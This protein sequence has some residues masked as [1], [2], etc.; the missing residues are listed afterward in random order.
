MSNK[1]K[2][3]KFLLEKPGYLKRSALNLQR[4]FFKDIKLQEV[5]DTLLQT[6]KEHTY[7]QYPLTPKECIQPTKRLFYDI[8]TSPNLVFSWSI[9]N[10]IS[11]GMDN[12][13][14]ERKIICI[15]YKWEHEEETHCITFN[16]N[17]Q[18]DKTMLQAFAKVLDQADEVCGHNLDNYDTKFLR[19][20]CILHGIQIPPKL[21]SIDTLKEA[22]KQFRFNSNKLDYIAKFLGLGAKIKTEYDLWKNIILNKDL[23]SLNKMAEYCKHDVELT[24]QVYHKLEPFTVGKKY[25]YVKK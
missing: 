3:R 7:K 12:I 21:N 18:D 6:R 2:I 17:S 1:D 13:V 11:L 10:R 4:E 23:K 8:E 25:K 22:R 14:Q 9:G 24:E 19:T 20:R 5:Y 16:I 15:G